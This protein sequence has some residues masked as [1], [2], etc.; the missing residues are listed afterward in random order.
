M[1][2]L[3]AVVAPAFGEG[4]DDLTALQ[5]GLTEDGIAYGLR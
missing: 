1:R 5:V 4:R 3:H 2:T